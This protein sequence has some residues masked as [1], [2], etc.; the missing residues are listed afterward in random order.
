MFGFFK[1]KELSP[2]QKIITQYKEKLSQLKE[3][4]EKINGDETIL[5]TAREV[6][7]SDLQILGELYGSLNKVENMIITDKDFKDNEKLMDSF[8]TPIGHYN[9]TIYVDSENYQR[10]I[11]EVD[12]IRSTEDIDY[13]EYYRNIQ[14]LFKK[15]DDIIYSRLKGKVKEL[16]IAKKL[17]KK[18]NRLIKNKFNELFSEEGIEKFLEEFSLNN[19]DFKDVYRFKFLESIHDVKQTEEPWQTVVAVPMTTLP[20]L[21]ILS[22]YTDDMLIK[23][24]ISLMFKGGQ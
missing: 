1:K 13:A 10:L 4:N 14:S 2:E 9:R 21:D 16:Y 17:T 7:L 15:K 20:E 5:D 23:N 24:N 3:L 6:I 19:V 22:E 11:N 8:L 12:Y 18:Y